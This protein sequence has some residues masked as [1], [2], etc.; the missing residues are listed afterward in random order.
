MTANVADCKMYW[1]EDYSGGSSDICFC[2]YEECS[3]ECHR[4][5]GGWFYSQCKKHLKDSFYYTLADFSKE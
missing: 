1:K 2:A 3:K 4:K 5:V